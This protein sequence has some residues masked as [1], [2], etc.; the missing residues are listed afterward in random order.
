MRPI[1]FRVIC[2]RGTVAGLAGENIS[3]EDGESMT[4]SEEERSYMSENIQQCASQ[5]SGP[6]RRTGVAVRVQNR[7]T[8]LRIIP[9]MFRNWP[10]LVFFRLRLRDRV[11]AKW[12]SGGS[13]AIQSMQEWFNL[14][15][16]P[17]WGQEF[18]RA[19]GFAV[20]VKDDV[21][22][23]TFQGNVLRF[24]AESLVRSFGMLVEQFVQEQY[25]WLDVKGKRVLDVGANI[26]DSAIYFAI[27][28]AS[29]V[30]SFE[31]YPYTFQL[32]KR[33]V[34]L[35][36]LEKQITLLNMGCGKE[37]SIT[38]NPELRSEP[39]S[40]L[41][42]NEAG[43]TVR[44]VS[45]KHIVEDYGLND[46]V[47]K[48]DGEGCEYELILG[49][50]DRELQAFSRMMIEYH[51]GY[52]SL[53]DRLRGVGFHVTHSRPFDFLNPVTGETE[54]VGFIKAFKLEQ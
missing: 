13:V 3:C 41:V 50:S 5:A 12:R 10:Q 9:R 31:P 4:A 51:H 43:E 33:N 15:K 45:L 38:V 24:Q 36:G 17:L 14:P 18:L 35:N 16:D 26:G 21:A 6:H 47:A 27:S 20:A 54:V 29:H 1:D 23:L 42:P 52:A 40:T 39:S 30:Y 28:G 53:V 19:Y 22:E 11:V 44:I 2:E 34:Q 37:G 25:K 48:V 8:Q 46:A 32:A 49:A 7:L